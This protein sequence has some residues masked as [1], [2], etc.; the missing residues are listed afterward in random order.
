[1]GLLAAMTDLDA[2]TL[3]MGNAIFTEFK[4]R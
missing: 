4:E 3:L 1:M 2:K